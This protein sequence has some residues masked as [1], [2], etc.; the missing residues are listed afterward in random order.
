MFNSLIGGAPPAAPPT[1][2]P[3]AVVGSSNGSADA[4]I[5]SGPYPSVKRTDNP[6]LVLAL[7]VLGA[8]GLLAGLN[9][10]G[11]RSTITV[12]RA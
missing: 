9:I 11:F 6:P 7:V 10:A 8:V 1:G 5:G 4:M 3:V 2:S 12:G